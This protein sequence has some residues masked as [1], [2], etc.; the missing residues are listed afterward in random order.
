MTNGKREKTCNWRPA[1]QNMQTA[2]IAGKHVIIPVIGRK[3][4]QKSNDDIGRKDNPCPKWPSVEIVM[5]CPRPL[6]LH[7][8]GHKG[9]VN[10]V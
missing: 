4:C 10:D 2:A 8:S 6:A 5:V 1:R 3:R 9:K 7:L